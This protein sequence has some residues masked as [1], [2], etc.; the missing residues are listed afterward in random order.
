MGTTGLLPTWVGELVTQLQQPAVLTGVLFL[1]V[2]G[3]L[4]LQLW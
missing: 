4:A 1:V 3:Y 2:L